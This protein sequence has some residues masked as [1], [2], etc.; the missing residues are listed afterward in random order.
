MLEGT[1]LIMLF[2]FH[3]N[4]A[5]LRLPSDCVALV[6]Y[7]FVF[8][9][10]VIVRKTSSSL[11]K[12]LVG[13]LGPFFIGTGTSGRAGCHPVTAELKSLSLD[14]LCTFSSMRC[15]ASSGE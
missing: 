12:V 7:T 3:S 13:S 5:I 6:R 10:L 15:T 1:S 9:N 4:P 2:E 8:P 14:A 11:P